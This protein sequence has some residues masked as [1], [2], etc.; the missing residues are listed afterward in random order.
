MKLLNFK[1]LGVDGQ[2]FEL[3]VRELLFLK[4]FQ[5][6]WSGKGPDGGQDLLCIEKRESFFAA[7]EKKWLIQCKHNANSEK[8]VGV[9]DL[10][11][12][13]DS[14]EQ[15]GADGYILVC[16]TYP[17]SSVVKRLEAITNNPK[18]NITAIYWDSVKIEQ[19][20]TTP[21]LWRVAQRFMP[22]SSESTTWKVY[23]TENPNHWVVNYLGYYFHLTNRIGSNH[24]HHFDSINKRIE[25]IKNVDLPKKHFIRIRSVYYDDK[26]G[27]YVWYIDY[28]YPHNH[29][30]KY[31]SAQLKGLLGD[32]YALDDGQLY[33][34]EVLLRTYSEWSDHYDPDHYDYYTPYMRSYLTGTERNREYEEYR[35][36]IV[37]NDELKNSLEKEKKEMFDTL[38]LKFDE[39]EILKVIRACNACMEDL[40]KFSIQKN[41]EDVIEEFEIDTA[42]FFSSWFFFDVKDENEFHKLISY[43]PQH[44]N[45]HFRLTR[46]YIYLPNDD[47]SGS[48]LDWDINEFLYEL[49]LSIHPINV[50]NKFIARKNL[51]NYFK[52]VINAIDKYKED[53]K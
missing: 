46:S 26:N 6:Y 24:E 9:K 45:Y 20:L 13:L 35:E 43:I 4:G 44:I 48:K 37:A 52:L 38:V 27:C 1:E 32:G 23:A 29:S 21:Q 31:S 28:M 49:T 5:V 2:D 12:I 36:A 34:F 47:M 25:E 40:D 22:V 14:C 8:A 39:L 15:H 42:R 10:D 41:W 30:P 17:S 50:Y 51:N 53:N 16:S 3:L 7:D 18:N 33:R 11:N 19:M